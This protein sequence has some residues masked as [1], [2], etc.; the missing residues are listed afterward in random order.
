MSTITARRMLFAVIAGATALTLA[1]CNSSASDTSST[2]SSSGSVVWVDGGGSYHDA[3]QKGILDPYT[4]ATGTQ[5]SVES[6]TD[7]AKLRSMVDAN[8]VV[9]D[10]YNGDNTWGTSADADFLEPLDYSV[11]PKDEILDG[12][13]SDYR[14]ANTLYSI[15]LAYN[16]KSVTTGRPREIH[17]RARVLTSGYAGGTVKARITLP[18]GEEGI[19]SIPTLG[20]DYTTGVSIDLYLRADRAIVLP[21]DGRA[22]L[23]DAQAS[24]NTLEPS[25]ANHG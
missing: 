10:V 25:G 11:I 21:T 13:A 14:V 3:M 22:I 1:A 12:Y 5:V 19:V 16:T 6:G 2:S 17:V 4:A 15:V 24:P 9:W 18:T 8:R 20:A 23:A 7:N